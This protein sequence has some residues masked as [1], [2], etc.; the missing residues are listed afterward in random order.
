M[1]STVRRLLSLL[2]FCALTGLV[3]AHAN[4]HG[5]S[6]GPEP[7]KFDMNLDNVS[8]NGR[9]LHL[10]LILEPATPEA[11]HLIAGYKPMIQHQIILLLSGETSQNLMTLDGKRQLAEKILKAANH[12]LDENTETGVKEVLFSDFLIQ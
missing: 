2:L 5:G 8:S 7:L 6:S 3:P 10:V 4:E 11:G 9:F 1:S 12:V